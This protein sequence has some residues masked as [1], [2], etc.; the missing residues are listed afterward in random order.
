MGK[1]VSMGDEFRSRREIVKIVGKDGKELYKKY[2]L[3]D[4]F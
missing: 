2:S 3:E 1:G 4:L